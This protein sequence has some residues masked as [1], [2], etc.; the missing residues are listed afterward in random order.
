MDTDL[1]YHGT[2]S[3]GLKQKEVSVLSPVIGVESEKNKSKE[4]VKMQSK[5]HNNK[6]RF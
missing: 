3:F 1:I 6:K 4:S 5:V 2:A